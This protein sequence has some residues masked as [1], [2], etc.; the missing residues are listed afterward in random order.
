M[1][2]ALS[3]VDFCDLGRRSMAG[4]HGQEHK[5]ASDSKVRSLCVL[6]PALVCRG[7]CAC[8]LPRL[9]PPF[10]LMDGRKAGGW[11]QQR[12]L[13]AWRPATIAQG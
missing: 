11:W 12:S 10:A 13:G 7:L 1:R 6:P 8:P 3:P 4:D 5:R 9:H 2:F